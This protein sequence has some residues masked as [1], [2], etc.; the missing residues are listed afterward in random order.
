MGAA[1]DTRKGDP[2]STWQ[3][4]QWHT[5]TRAGSISALN[6]IRPQWQAPSMCMLTPRSGRVVSRSIRFPKR[7]QCRHAPAV[8]EVPVTKALGHPA[9][10]DPELAPQRRPGDEHGQ[11]TAPLIARQGGADEG[12]EEPRVD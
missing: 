8:R 6:V 10:L 7:Y 11:R 12:E 2:E 4:V 9:L 1:T 3:S 5:M